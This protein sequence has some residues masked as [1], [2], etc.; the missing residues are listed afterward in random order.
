MDEVAKA[1]HCTWNARWGNASR[2][3]HRLY[4]KTRTG[5]QSDESWLERAVKHLL[6]DSDTDGINIKNLVMI[7]MKRDLRLLKAETS[8]PDPIVTKIEQPFQEVN[9]DEPTSDAEEDA[10]ED[11]EED[12]EDE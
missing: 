3:E 5:A 7:E 8:E 2:E 9:T 4:Q 6:T 12:A 11:T 1:A 10:E